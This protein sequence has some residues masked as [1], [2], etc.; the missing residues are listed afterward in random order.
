MKK[1]SRRPLKY[2]AIGLVLALLAMLP[3]LPFIKPHYVDL[4]VIIGIETMVTLGLC[5]LTGYTG[6]I[7]LGQAAF[8]GLG[9]YIS[10]ILSKTYGISPWAAM[11]IGAVATGGFAYAIGLPVLRLKGNY[12]AMAT[13]AVGII[14]SMVFEQ[15]ASITGGH[16]GI[17][18]I[19]QLAIGGFAFDSDRKFY[20]LAWAFCLAVLLVSQ[21]IVGSRTGRAL[22]A[23]RDSEAAAE[24]VGINVLQLK[25]KVFTLSAVFASLAGSLLAH[26]RTAIG[27]GAFSFLFSIKAVVMA[28][29]GGL[30]SVWGAIFGTGAVQWLSDALQEFGDYQIIAFGL[31]LV[32]VVMFLPRGL[33]V[34]LRDWIA[35]RRRSRLKRAE[36]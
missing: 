7:S 5:L 18:S 8:Y 13:L 4:A 6:Q 28:V 17:Q 22:R 36:G 1:T 33:W 26:Y 35:R 11:G 14:V 19:P 32:L 20:Y 29:V 16:D 25:A 2:G 9:A 21:N 12:L 15:A 31:V 3:W 23:V 34:S 27:P 30:A 10:A 24:S